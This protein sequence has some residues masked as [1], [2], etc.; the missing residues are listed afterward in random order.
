MHLGIRLEARSEEEKLVHRK[1]YYSNVLLDQ[2]T[3][4]QTLVH[5]KELLR[6]HYLTDL[7]TEAIKGMRKAKARP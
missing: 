2:V 5:Q 7:T 1:H 6:R 3:F 4:Y